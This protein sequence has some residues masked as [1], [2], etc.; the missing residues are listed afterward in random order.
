MT[1]HAQNGSIL[2]HNL[3]EHNHKIKTAE[4]LD[5]VT[6]LHSSQDRHELQIAEALFI[7]DLKP[8]INSQKEGEVRIL[9]IF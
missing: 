2:N 9:H 1:T 8:P 5:R 4:I 7:K 6:V 3:T